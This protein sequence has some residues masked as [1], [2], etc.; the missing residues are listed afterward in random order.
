MAL[1]SFVACLPAFLPAAIKSTGFPLLLIFPA[2]HPTLHHLM[3]PYFIASSSQVCIPHTNWSS[4][5]DSNAHGYQSFLL[6]KGYERIYLPEGLKVWFV[7]EGTGRGVPCIHLAPLPSISRT[8][9]NSG[10]R[11]MKG[12]ALSTQLP[13]LGLLWH[14]HLF[15]TAYHGVR[16]D[17]I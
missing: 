4:V 9:P 6:S 16:P 3:P 13:P 7:G 12:I 1:C 17:D 15:F 2:I 8:A 5:F 14:G 11:R 10:Y